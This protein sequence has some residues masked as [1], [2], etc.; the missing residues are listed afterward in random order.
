MDP[1]KMYF[2]SIK[3]G[4]YSIAMLV[5]QRV[6]MASTLMSVESGEE[7][8]HIQTL[9]HAMTRNLTCT[10]KML[11]W[12]KKFRF[13]HGN[14]WCPSRFK[15]AWSYWLENMF[16][17]FFLLVLGEFVGVGTTLFKSS[18][19]VTIFPLKFVI[20]EFIDGTIWCELMRLQS[21]NR[22]LDLLFFLFKGF[23]IDYPPVN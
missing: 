10:L 5:Y 16:G 7:I 20:C 14:C 1:L 11:V 13:E 17:I 12:N 9:S 15:N 19:L 2:L 18:W 3:N 21:P 22:R 6:Y 4:R 23:G 8:N